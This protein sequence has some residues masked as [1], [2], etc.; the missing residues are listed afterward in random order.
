MPAISTA[1]SRRILPLNDN[2]V[3]RRAPPREK[4]QGGIIIPDDAQKPAT[5][6]TVLYVGP[7]RRDALGRRIEPWVKAGDE[8][9]FGEYSVN[10]EFEFE[11]EKVVFMREEEDLYARID[12][13]LLAS[14]L[15]YPL[16]D[17]VLVE[18]QPDEDRTAGG[19]YIPQQAR[20][21]AM[22][23]KVLQV[24]PGRMHTPKNAPAARRPVEVA[25]GD[26]VVFGKY[27]SGDFELHGQKLLFLR[28]GDL[29]AVE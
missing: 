16:G 25:A 8:V 23:G 27:S 20:E 13:D 2:I 18:R 12:G 14:A 4:S 29:L 10:A 3:V 17:T 6:G 22:R 24:G 19:L 26:I 1:A 21:Q 28:E 5:R 15:I 9:L 7:G 11:G